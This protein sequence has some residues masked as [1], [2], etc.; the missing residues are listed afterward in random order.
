MLERRISPS[1]RKLAVGVNIHLIPTGVNVILTRGGG[2]G[3][4]PEAR[5]ATQTPTGHSVRLLG[6][7]VELLWGPCLKI[8]ARGFARAASTSLSQPCGGHGQFRAFA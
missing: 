8:G 3:G 6:E 1:L 5:S 4:S 2:Q 7:T